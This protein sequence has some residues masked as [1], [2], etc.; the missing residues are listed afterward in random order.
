MAQRSR[1]SAIPAD[2][3]P[4]FKPAWVEKSIWVQIEADY[5]AGVRSLRDIASEAGITEGAI[6]KRAKRDQWQ[7]DLKAR[8]SARAEEKVRTQAVRI[9]GTQLTPETEQQV[10]EANADV[11][12]AVRISHRAGLQR[13]K[14]LKDKL[15]EQVTHESATHREA[16]DDLRK[17]TEIDEKIRKGEREA[18]NI[19]DPDSENERKPKRITLDFIDV[20][21]K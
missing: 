20:E 10:V 6:R 21:A 8:I 17:L 3:C 16:I 9:A 5:R 11:E 7:R 13:L 12:Y 14:E 2:S 18:F 19:G 1:R 4:S 15:L